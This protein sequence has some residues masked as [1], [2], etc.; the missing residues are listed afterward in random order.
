MSRVILFLPAL[1]LASIAPAQAVVSRPAG[2][3]L[4]QAAVQ[5]PEQ[6]IALLEKRI[7][8]FEERFKG[9]THE[10]TYWAVGLLSEP[11]NGRRVNLAINPRSERSRTSP[12]PLAAPGNTPPAPAPAP[13]PTNAPKPVTQTV[14]SA[15]LLATSEQRIAL[16]EK[17]IAAFEDRFKVHT[18]EYSDWAVG[19]LS[20]P[21]NGRRINLAIS[22]RVEKP[23]TGPP[24]Q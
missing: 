18:H 7:A 4:S 19:L 1:F 15:P 12:V 5:T 11:I 23:R 24:Q 20:E 6:R 2:N 22:P 9:H 14:V 21:I 3:A 17:R 16:L 8:A 10:Y 13:A